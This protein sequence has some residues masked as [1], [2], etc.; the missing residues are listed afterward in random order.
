MLFSIYLGGLVHEF[1]ERIEI[2]K[3]LLLK[4]VLIIKYLIPVLISLFESYGPMYIY[5]RGKN[6]KLSIELCTKMQLD[7]STLKTCN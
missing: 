6:V 2:I 7:N 5:F 3:Q 1:R 4:L